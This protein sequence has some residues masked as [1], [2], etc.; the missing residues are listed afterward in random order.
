MVL[1]VGFILN[2]NS[3]ILSWLKIVG[4]K[5]KLIDYND[6]MSTTKLIKR[7]IG[8]K[9]SYMIYEN[10]GEFKV[11]YYKKSSG[12]SEPKIHIFM[13]L[14]QALAYGESLGVK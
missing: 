5:R 6:Y 7:V 3:L 9:S 8:K 12:E 14:A 1:M 13:D 4:Y 10:S 11:H 2:W